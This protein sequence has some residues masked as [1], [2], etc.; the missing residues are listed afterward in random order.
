M[1][2]VYDEK[3]LCA[4]I[5]KPQEG[6]TWCCLANIETNKGFYHFI[7]TM[8]TI[9]SNL[10]FFERARSRFGNKICVFNSKEKKKE[11]TPNFNHA[12]D[13][14]GVKQSIL[15]GSE[16]IIMCA[17]PKRFDESIIQLLEILEDSKRFNKNVTTEPQ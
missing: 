8:N 10:Q 1:S 2:D 15:N 4:I 14:T 12:K 3:Y 6:K 17:H 7:I 9:K 11:Q 5:R 13:V 16:I